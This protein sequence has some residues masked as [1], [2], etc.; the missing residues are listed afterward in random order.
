MPP[1]PIEQMATSK[2]GWSCRHSSAA[3]E[4]PRTSVS[5]SKAWTYLKPLV[6]AW[7]KAASFSKARRRPSPTPY[8]F[9]ANGSRSRLP[10]EALRRKPLLPLREKVREARMR[11]ALDAFLS[12]GS[13]QFLQKSSIE[14]SLRRPLLP[15]PSANFF[16][17]RRRN[18]SAPR[19]SPPARPRA[20]CAWKRP[21]LYELA[22]C[23]KR[24][25]LPPNKRR[26]IGVHPKTETR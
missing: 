1:P 14:K 13:S 4:W 19:S 26:T 9:G 3:V 24:G 22:L 25:A 20:G 18:Q 11:G 5:S 8:R 21:F 16:R 15:W 12:A 23:E 7:A 17:R 10:A 6:L 2:C